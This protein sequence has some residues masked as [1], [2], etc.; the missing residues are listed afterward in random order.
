MSNSS[1]ETDWNNL[2]SSI[3]DLEYLKD[4]HKNPSIQKSA[5]ELIQIISTHGDVMKHDQFRYADENFSE[6]KDKSQK[7]NTNTY[8]SAIRDIED[9]EIPIKGHGL[10]SLTNLV[11]QN[12]AEVIKNFDQIIRIF[13]STLEHEDTYLYL[14]SVKEHL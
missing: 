1:N 11:T 13:Q 4:N 14:L 12:E 8:A 3:S 6:T 5:G 10:I 7:K 2:E 9:S